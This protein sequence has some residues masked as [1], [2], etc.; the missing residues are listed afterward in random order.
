MSQ[1]V[2]S[3]TTSKISIKNSSLSYVS[4][5]P[6]IS[7]HYFLPQ[8]KLNATSVQWSKNTVLG[9]QLKNHSRKLFELSASNFE[10]AAKILHAKTNSASY[11]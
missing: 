10:Q 9:S 4:H 6:V 5:N 2:N 8:N 11:P 3:S 7:C 1:V